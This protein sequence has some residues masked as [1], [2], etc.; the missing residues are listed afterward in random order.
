MIVG[1][2]GRRV[3][4]HGLLS[5]IARCVGRN[6]VPS[7]DPATMVLR[8]TR[9]R[10]GTLENHDLLRQLARCPLSIPYV[11]LTVRIVL[12]PSQKLDHDGAASPRPA[13]P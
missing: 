2:D 1:S 3:G 6:F 4:R 12:S 13:A 11:K 9:S 5:L 10:S 7:S 8:D